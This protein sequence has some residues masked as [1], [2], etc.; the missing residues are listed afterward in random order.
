MVTDWEAVVADLKRQLQTKDSHGRREL[1]TRLG[2]L[3]AKHRLDE[4][5][6]ERALRVSGAK[7]SEELIKQG[8]APDGDLAAGAV[9]NGAK[10]HLS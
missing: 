3:E 10:A 5:L 4:G 2:E 9:A 7:L 6:V 1:L 8:R